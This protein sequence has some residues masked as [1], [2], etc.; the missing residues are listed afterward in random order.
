[1]S[2][3]DRARA[4]RAA[5]RARIESEAAR[6]FAQRGYAATTIDDIAAAAG[7]SKPMLYRHFSSKR[8]LHMVLLERHRDE[9]AA[10]PLE[11]LLHGEGDLDAR[12]AAMIEAWFA[13][14]ESSPYTWRMLFRDTTGDPDVQ[15]EHRRI[16]ARQRETDVALLRRFA[17][18]IAE[19]ELEPLGE[20]VRSSLYGVALW[21][22]EHQDVP[23]AV[24][25]GAMLRVLRGLAVPPPGA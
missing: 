24:V 4:E 20:A 8:E 6:L 12:L 22:L 17:P 1:M 7:L 2:H 19:E 18:W 13:R 16:Q 9:L 3:L 5:V 14:V 15:E 10:A 11:E 25:V 23:R 21:W